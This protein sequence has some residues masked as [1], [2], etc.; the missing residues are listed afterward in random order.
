MT[1]EAL[2]RQ[3]VVYLAAAVLAVPVAS[4]LGLGSVLGYLLAGVAIGPWALGLVAEETRHV[5]HFAELGV[6]MMLF[7]VG[8]ELDPGRLWRLRVPV[9]GY[10]GL[11]VLGTAALVAPAAMAVGLVWQQA[12]A[13]GL[14]VAMSSTA[15]A[16][17][18]LSEKGLLRTAPGQTSF[19]I[20]LF[21]DV[22]VI[23]ILALFP[24]LATLD[25]HADGAGHGGSFVDDLPGWQHALVV[26]GAV[27]A[28]V[29][30]GRL[31][32]GPL[33]RAV[34]R[35]GL[36]EMFT[37]S[38]LLI[39]LAVALL[40]G[41]V[42]LSA[43]LGTF[44]AG[45]VLANSEFRH[46]L[47]SDV[48]PFKGLLL[49]LFF[50]AV[51]ASIDF[52]V[53][54]QAPLAVAGALV[55]LM[56]AKALVLGAIARW[57]GL[58]AV[59]GALLAL[60]LPQIG[61]F[62]FVLFSFAET[63]GILSATVTAP[64]VAVTAFSMAATPFL[65]TFHERVVAPRLAAAAAGSSR[66]HD[67]RDEHDPVI[68]AG[69]GRFGQITARMLRSHGVGVTVLDVDSTQIDVLR[70]FGHKAWYGDASRLDLLRAAGAATA[71]V[72][73]IAVDEHEKALEIARV[74][75]THFPHLAILARA[76][77]RTEAYELVEREV[78]G[79]YRETFDTAVRVAGDAMRLLG[80]PAHAAHRAARLFRVHDEASLLEMARFRGDEHYVS[81][82]RERV[83]EVERVL[84]ADHDGQGHD[85][86]GHGW[87][88][89]SERPP[90]PDGGPDP[91]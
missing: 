27:G 4:R 70:T 16:L 41:A 64:M 30:A 14:I 53:L 84:R 44:V 15:I 20:L 43:A 21:Q 77:G 72:L 80:T 36:R 63:N 31:L 19:A 88:D 23:P 74:A 1:V 33:M 56:A 2:L 8:L 22:A 24:L 6:V 37:A 71:T 35:T 86:S 75:Q 55:G 50:I 81:R 13:L 49:G 61:E 67:L 32:I 90:P 78:A 25:P 12:V 40:M 5:M 91:A 69:F 47:M 42:G 68:V 60:A 58:S 59:H 87:A 46:E 45:V 73:V 76:R 7:L 18:S 54:G 51:G 83:S 17:Q 26:L 52:S 34:A 28:V 9:F 82:V 10:G 48:E 62:A 66:E 11:Q 57:E 85:A 89:R 29:G 65:L 3:G 79:V 39:V 38:A